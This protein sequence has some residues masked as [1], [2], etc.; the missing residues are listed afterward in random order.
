MGLRAGGCPSGWRENDG[1]RDRKNQKGYSKHKC[2]LLG[3]K[4]REGMLVETT[5]KGSRHMSVGLGAIS[6][7]KKIKLGSPNTSENKPHSIRQG[8]P[9][10]VSH[11][12]IEA[13]TNARRN[14]LTGTCWR[15]PLAE[16]P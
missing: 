9:R 7:R 3:R 8:Q 14:A 15:L 12:L 10:I 2:L 5:T 16:F 4:D 13:E 11:C 6:R 1:E